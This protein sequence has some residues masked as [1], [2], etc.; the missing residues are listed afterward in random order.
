[1]GRSRSTRIAR[2]GCTAWDEVL[3]PSL[4][5]IATA[6][7]V[8]YMGGEPVFV[9]VDP[10]T[11][12]I[13]P[14]GLEQAITPKT[15]GIIAVHLYGH[16]ADMDAINKVAAAHGLWVVRTPPEAHFARYKGRLV[17]GLADIATFSFYGNKIIASGEGGAG[18]VER[19]IPCAPY[20]HARGQ[21]M[22][23]AR[24][25]LFSDHCYNYRLTNIA[26]A[27]LCAQL[28]RAQEIISRRQA[29]FD[30]YRKRLD[31]IPGLS[32]SQ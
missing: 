11:W 9:D 1:M 21:G 17:G 8:R 24:P 5:Y 19:S 15:K 18:H 31:G 20:K 2:L 22:D 32:F 29:V 16:P 28:E 26:A 3:V 23:L 10:H 25:I 30:F 27:L 6:N 7:A 4:T 12:C 14:S 13:S